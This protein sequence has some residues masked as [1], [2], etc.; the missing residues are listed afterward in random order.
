VEPLE[1]R[2]FGRDDTDRPRRE[3][4]RAELG[5]EFGPGAD[6]TGDARLILGPRGARGGPEHRHSDARIA[7]EVRRW[8]MDDVRLDRAEIDVEVSNGDVVLRGRV[9]DGRAKRLAADIAY[10]VPGVR[11]VSPE[12]RIDGRAA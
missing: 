11:H 8:L 7:H 9:A 4:Q 12:L 2:Y 1:R 5:Y 10:A 6:A 3:P